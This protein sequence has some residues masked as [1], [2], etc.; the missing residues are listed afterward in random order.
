MGILNVTWMA[1]KNT[2]LYFW[3]RTIKQPTYG[4][5]YFSVRVGDDRGNYFRYTAS[6]GLLNAA[7]LLWKQYKMPLSGNSQFAR[8]VSGAMS[9]TNVNYVEFHAD[10]WDY[11]FT[12]WV[13]G[14]QFS[15]CSP[16]TGLEESTGRIP[17]E[18]GIYPNPFTEAA[19]IRL[20]LPERETVK[21]E[22]FDLRGVKT[23][24]IASSPLPAGVHLF[25][26]TPPAPGLYILKLTTPSANYSVKVLRVR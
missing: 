2:T 22:L 25:D 5:Q 15:P 19:T 17:P 16:V 9:L 14:V 20:F 18:L 3:V 21:L 6:P 10:T 8:S 26:C 4:F 24:S 13:D 1:F 7:N 23:R 12:L 11:G